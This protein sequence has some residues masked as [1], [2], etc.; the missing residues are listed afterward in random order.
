MGGNGTGKMVELVVVVGLGQG[1]VF[2]RVRDNA[3][4]RRGR[5]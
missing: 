5:V 4:C 1:V 2:R 3:L